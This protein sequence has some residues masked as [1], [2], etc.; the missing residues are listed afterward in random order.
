MRDGLRTR[1][2]RWCAGHAGFHAHRVICHLYSKRIIAEIKSGMQLQEAGKWL[3]QWFKGRLGRLFMWKAN[4]AA[5]TLRN[6]G[7]QVEI[8]ELVD[9]RWWWS[10]KKLSLVPCREDMKRLGPWGRV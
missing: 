10:C 1:D 7:F 8:D 4:R 6:A 9:I 2:V 5:A 3:F